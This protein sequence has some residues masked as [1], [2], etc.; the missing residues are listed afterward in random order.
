MAPV[1]CHARHSVYNDRLGLAPRPPPLRHSERAWER[2]IS[3]DCKKLHL[4]MRAQRDVGD[5]SLAL[6][7]TL[8]VGVVSALYLG[9]R[10]GWCGRFGLAPRPPPLRHSERARERRIS[11]RE[12]ESLGLRQRRFEE[13][14]ALIT[15]L[16]YQEHCFPHGRCSL[17]RDPSLTLRMTL[18]VQDEVGDGGGGGPLPAA[19]FR[20][21]WSVGFGAA[22]PPLASF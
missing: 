3:P 16:F 12:A 4:V 14:P 15:E 10:F 1:L 8:R 7:M 5:P 21:V 19:S 22:P 6:R 11:W 20:V 17:L 18:G 13:Q 2:R 9:D